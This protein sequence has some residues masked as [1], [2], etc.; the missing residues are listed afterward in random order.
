MKRENFHVVTVSVVCRDSNSDECL[1]TLNDFIGENG[2]GVYSL[3]SIV[4]PIKKQEYDEL[5]EMTPSDILGS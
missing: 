1:R 5:V 4:R 3:E 2:I